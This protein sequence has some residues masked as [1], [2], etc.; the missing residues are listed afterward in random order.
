MSAAPPASKLPFA[1][2]LAAL[3]LCAA[4]AS[5]PAATPRVHAIT[6]AR[7][8]VAPGQVIERGTVVMRDG[9]IVAVGGA[10]AGRLQHG[11]LR[12]L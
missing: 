4:A 3:A 10:Q 2:A 5:A 7:V 9:I 12:V 11:Y 8:V 1:L 6:N